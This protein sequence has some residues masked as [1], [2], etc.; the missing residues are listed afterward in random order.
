MRRHVERAVA[1]RLLSLPPRVVRVL[2]GPAVQVDGQVLDPLAQLGLRLDRLSGRA[3][4]ETLSP[5]EAR[6]DAA[7][8]LG[9][10]S[11]TP[12]VMAEVRDLEVPGP[13]GLLPARLHRPHGGRGADPL[14]V[15]FHGGGFVIGGLDT[16]DEHCRRLAAR[17]GVPV[18]SVD[19]RLAPEARFP[20][21]VEDA[22]AAFRW[23]REEAEALGVDPD[24]VAVGGDSAGGNLATVVSLL[25]ARAGEPTP[26]YQVLLYPLTDVSERRASHRLFGSGFALDLPL[27]DWFTSQYLGGQNP[28][29]VRVS[30]LLAPE[31]DLAGMPPAY[32]AAAGF[33]PLRD[34]ALAWARRLAAAGVEVHA[35]CHRS[36]IHGFCSFAGVMPAAQEA[37][38]AAADHLRQTLVED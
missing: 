28:A 9:I 11:S 1:R 12:A 20:A 21:A 17:S 6:A 31:D 14:L 25:T 26:A 15:Y 24:R 2:G 33:D 7:R 10:F 32:V 19:Y 38:H 35:T 29:D 27:I 37:V 4:M 8:T 34:E 5:A 23:A 13:A 3:P 18:L 16:H 22:L 30:P 36:L